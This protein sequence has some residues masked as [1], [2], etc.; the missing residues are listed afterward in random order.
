[1]RPGALRAPIYGLVGLYRCLG[2]IFCGYLSI[3]VHRPHCS[4][5]RACA[6][7]SNAT[8]HTVLLYYCSCLI[9]LCLCLIILLHVRAYARAMGPRARVLTSNAG[10]LLCYKP[11]YYIIII[12]FTWLVFYSLLW[13]Q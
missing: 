10:T 8:G 2:W 13:K 11:N 7:M 6:R 5:V 1:M 3:T 4:C 9:I 12:R